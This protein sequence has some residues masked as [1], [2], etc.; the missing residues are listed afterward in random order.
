MQTLQAVLPR[1]QHL[2]HACVP[3][4]FI[5]EVRRLLCR[6]IPA[7]EAM[8]TYH[9]GAQDLQR[10]PVCKAW[11][12]LLLFCRDTVERH[13]AMRHLSLKSQL[14]L[15]PTFVKQQV[16]QGGVRRELQGLRRV[17]VVQG[18]GAAT[19]QA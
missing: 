19:G 12:Q 18:A 15:M 11:P 17:W 1:P 3:L 2:K 16:R 13:L 9:L 8:K 6:A 4:G 5:I 7:K 10:L 14:V